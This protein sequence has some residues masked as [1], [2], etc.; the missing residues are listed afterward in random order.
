M[1]VVQCQTVQHA[2][3]EDAQEDRGAH[4]WKQHGPQTSNASDSRIL[5]RGTL[6]QAGGDA[7]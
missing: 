7:C 6:E 2:C 3:G 4:A 5:R 1:L